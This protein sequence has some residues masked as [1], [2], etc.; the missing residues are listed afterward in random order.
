M[1]ICFETLCFSSRLEPGDEDHS[2]AAVAIASPVDRQILPNM[3]EDL[4]SLLQVKD[5]RI[6]ELEDLLKR[7]DDE[8]RELRIHLDK[9]QSVISR[10]D[11]FDRVIHNNNV[12]TRK[13]RAGISA[14]PNMEISLHMKFSTYDKEER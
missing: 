6:L 3:A 13:Q 9:F 8:I 12:R 14:E 4:S 11:P 10:C 5:Q 2:T 7:R 1:R